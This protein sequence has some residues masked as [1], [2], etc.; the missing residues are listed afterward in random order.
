[1]LSHSLDHR[2]DRLL[3][4]LLS[5]I[6]CLGIS[7]NFLTITSVVVAIPAT[8]LFGLGQGLWGGLI[9]LISGLFDILDGA[10]ART[11]GK[12]TRFGGFLDSVLDRYVDLGIL[13][14]IAYYYGSSGQK[15]LLLWTLM[16]MSGTALIPYVRARAE[17]IIPRCS[18]G[19][20]ERPERIIML[21]A[22]GIFNLLPY[23]IFVLALLTHVTTLQRII[24]TRR[25]DSEFRSQK[26]SN[27]R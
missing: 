13:A 10:L 15:T 7:P 3:S 2:L 5:R 20:A 9:L 24:F 17:L 27:G 26:N 6:H 16:A 11:Q 23:A 14:G 8:I 21:A 19:I 18:I 1:M 22:G 25:Q 4:G 12:V